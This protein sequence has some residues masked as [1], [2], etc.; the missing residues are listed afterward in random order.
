MPSVRHEASTYSLY[1]RPEIALGLLAATGVALPEHD[2]VHVDSPKLPD[3]VPTDFEADA[4]FTVLRS[5]TPVLSLILEIQLRWDDDKTWV[6][7][8]YLANLRERRRCPVHLLVICL[9]PR[10][11][12]RCAQPIDL[13]HPGFVLTPTVIGP[14]EIPRVTDPAEATAQPALAVLS[15]LAHPRDEAVLAVLPAALSPMNHGTYAGY[16]RLIEAALPAAS[17]RFLEE[18]MRSA[19]TPYKSAWANHHHAEGYDEGLARAVLELLDARGVPIND[20]DRQQVIDCRDES[21]LLTWLR[22]A[23]TATSAEELFA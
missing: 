12:L 14:R 4:V 2:L 21:Q 3:L 20:R 7:P 22:K 18:L 9:G 19:R 13:G 1:Q 11:A 16:Y 15:A 17:R 23:A 10:T 8:A 5:G 6:W